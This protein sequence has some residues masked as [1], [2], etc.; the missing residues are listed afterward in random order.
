MS[1]LLRNMCS[2]AVVAVLATTVSAVDHPSA[3]T[4]VASVNGENITL[5]ELILVREGLPQQYAQ[6]P[7]DVLLDGIVEQLIQQVVL[8]QSLKGDLPTRV[9]IALTNETRMLKASNVIETLISGSV[10]EAAIQ[11]AY[12]AEYA[13]TTPGKEYNASHI[14]VETETEALSLI[15]QQQGGAD[16]AELARGHSTGPSGPSGGELGWFGEGMMVPA[17]EDAVKILA[18]GAVSQPVKTQFGWHVILLNETRPLAAP[19]L[20]KVREQLADKLGQ[21]IILAKVNELTEAA[22]ID[23]SGLETLDPELLSNI[24][25][26]K[27]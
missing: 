14:L 26:L 18:V 19:A 4:V 20:E 25:L 5:G 15:E 2:A 3:D 23:R 27:D 17:F 10:N 11:A 8:S 13:D 21:K 7:N 24:E 16:F 12:D 9:R 1:K 6:L 22:T